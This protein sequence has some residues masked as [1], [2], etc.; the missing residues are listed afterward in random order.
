ME[1]MVFYV[2]EEPALRADPLPS[3]PVCTCLD[4]VEVSFP[5]YLDEFVRVGLRAV[6]HLVV[7]AVAAAAA[8]PLG[9]VAVVFHL[10]VGAA[11]FVIAGC[12]MEG[13][14][15]VTVGLSYSGQWCQDPDSLA[16]AARQVT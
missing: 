10:S 9:V 13:G 16:R 4:G 3:V 2:H 8:A 5:G 14:M 11:V 1:V 6:A 15:V 12:P 7:A